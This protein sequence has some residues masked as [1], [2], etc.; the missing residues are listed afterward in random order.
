ML[1]FE[2]L[3][4]LCNVSGYD[5]GVVWIILY[6]QNLILIALA[7]NFYDM[8]RYLVVV[9]FHIYRSSV[10][11]DFATFLTDVYEIRSIES[12]TAFFAFETGADHPIVVS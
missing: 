3:P 12:V 6:Q 11:E 1:N 4:S 5:L 9:E 7:H 8:L 10:V 2:H